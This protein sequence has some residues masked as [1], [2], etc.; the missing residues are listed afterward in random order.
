MLRPRCG[1]GRRSEAV[2]SYRRRRASLGSPPRWQTFHFTQG[3][4]CA[5]MS[6][7]HG[8]GAGREN[9]LFFSFILSYFQ[10]CDFTVEPF[11]NLRF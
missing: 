8:V 4:N 10:T 2:P 11:G 9:D 6:D 1:G 3:V 5:T 7:T